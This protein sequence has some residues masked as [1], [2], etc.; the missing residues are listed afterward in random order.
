MERSLLID[1]E[2]GNDDEDGG[3]VDGGNDDLLNANIVDSKCLKHSLP[4]V[5][6]RFV[7]SSVHTTKLPPM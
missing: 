5:S 6:S 1:S 2:V 4:F 3:D 7:F